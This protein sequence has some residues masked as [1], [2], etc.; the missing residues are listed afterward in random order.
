MNTNNQ[1]SNFN[2][3][4]KKS[5]W[6]DIFLGIGLSL[7]LIIAMYASLY[8]G[9]AG[10]VSIVMLILISCSTFLAVRFI[11]RNRKIAGKILL[12]TVI[13]LTLILLLFG[14]CFVS[15]GEL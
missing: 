4:P 11:R 15:M 7:L 3:P 1:D 5:P 6:G 14:A 2:T 10:M 12:A 9:E 13:P 8:I